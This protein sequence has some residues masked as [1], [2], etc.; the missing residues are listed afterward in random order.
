ME[1]LAATDLAGVI[2]SLE[3]DHVLVLRAL[4]RERRR[5]GVHDLDRRAARVARDVALDDRK[6]TDRIND[7][8]DQRAAIPVSRV[9][10]TIRSVSVIPPRLV[11]TTTESRHYLTSIGLDVAVELERAAA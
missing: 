10:R 6:L 2:G 3:A 5:N 8:A 4:L 9:K 7:L 11:A 1:A